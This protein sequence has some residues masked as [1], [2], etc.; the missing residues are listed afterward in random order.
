MSNSLPQ[1]FLDFNK[2]RGP[3]APSWALPLPVFIIRRR[4]VESLAGN[5]TSYE[6]FDASYGAA[7]RWRPDI[8][9]ATQIMLSRPLY[10]ED[11]VRASGV[12]QPFSVAEIVH[13][14]HACRDELGVEVKFP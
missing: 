9:K 11:V 2:A 10:S 6:Y 8:T 13:I 5:L 12:G 1:W 14:D 4:T 7:G 3:N